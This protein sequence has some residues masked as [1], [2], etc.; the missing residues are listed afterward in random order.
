[1]ALGHLEQHHRHRRQS[2]RRLAAAD[3][4]HFHHR[5]DR[6]FRHCY[7]DPLADLSAVRGEER[8][9]IRTPHGVRYT[10]GATVCFENSNLAVTRDRQQF[11]V[12]D[13][14]ALA[15]LQ[16]GC[17]SA[18]IPPELSQLGNPRE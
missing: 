15:F 4:Q 9:G 2:D 1:M 11:R 10:P 3:D 16:V 8:S 14:E 12:T 18:S 17:A 13:N 6:L 7:S 5:R